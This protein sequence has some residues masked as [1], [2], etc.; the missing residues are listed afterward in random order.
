[1]YL[2]SEYDGFIGKIKIDLT[3]TRVVFECIFLK[4][5]HAPFNLTLTR[6]VFEYTYGNTQ[7]T[8]LYYLTLT[9]VVF[10]F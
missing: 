3:L 2:N 6:V 8:F 7:K 5:V 1:M 10:E 9:R 4:G